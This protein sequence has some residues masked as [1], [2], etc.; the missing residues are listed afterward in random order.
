MQFSKSPLDVND[1]I[2]LLRQKGLIINDVTQTTNYLSNIN[3]YRFRK[4]LYS[5]QNNQQPNRPIIVGTTFDQVIDLYFFDKSLRELVARALQ[6]VEVALRAQVINHFS[7]TYGSHWYEDANLYQNT[8]HFNRDMNTIAR[9]ISRSSETFILH[10]KRTY[11]Q[12]TNPPA[13]MTFEIISFGLLSKIYENLRNSPEKR[14]VARHFGL[15]VIVLISWMH[16]FSYVR[17]V[18]AHHSRLWNRQLVSAPR[19]PRRPRMQWLYQT[20]SNPR[21]PYVI[22]SAILYMLNTIDPQHQWKQDLKNLMTN[23]N[24][25]LSDMGF[26]QNWAS[27]PLWQ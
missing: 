26:P 15:P 17:N 11:T 16:T 10:Y 5:F 9:E 12:P 27:E 6:D 21:T 18:C 19:L 7:L 3:Y 2:N 1:Q 20:P 14:Q 22:L 4:Y 13:W 23:S 8:R 24:V 25:S